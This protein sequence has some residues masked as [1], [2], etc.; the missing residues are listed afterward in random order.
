[1][2]PSS[3]NLQGGTGIALDPLPPPQS[4]AD[5]GY[6]LQGTGSSSLLGASTTS[7]STTSGGYVAPDPYAQWGGQTGYNN[8]VNQIDT[9]LNNIRTS[10][11]DAFG[12]ATNQRQQG[13]NSFLSQFRTSQSGIDTSRQNN[14]LNRLGG[15]QDLLGYI[16]N[17]L[18]QGGSRLANMNATDSSATGALAQA[19]GQLGAQ[20]ARGIN[21]QAGL[22]SNSLNQQQGNLTQSWKDQQSQLNLT[23]DSVVNQIGQSVRASLSALDQQ[24]QGLSLPDRIAVEQEKQNIVNQGMTQLQGVDTW[25]QGQIAGIQPMS[26][27]QVQTGARGLQQAGAGL[28]NP[29][30]VGPISQSLVGSPQLDQLPLYSIRKNQQQF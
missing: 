12:N 20:K 11:S 25:L 9:G 24:A 17:G 2:F 7:G 6:Q 13:A 10:G 15:I 27:E 23:R 29:F 5:S 14:E 30:N 26:D 16:R 1:M 22:T 4:I 28:S 19:Y 3:V 18:H 8:A 21:N